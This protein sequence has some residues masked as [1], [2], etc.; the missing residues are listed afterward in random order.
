[1]SR[2]QNELHP[3]RSTCRRSAF[4]TM[5]SIE[6][7]EG[8]GTVRYFVKGQRVNLQAKGAELWFASA[9]LVN[10]DMAGG[11]ACACTFE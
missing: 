11:V 1:M 9:K 5:G 7:G 10:Q 6:P 4:A 2:L 3:G 8:A